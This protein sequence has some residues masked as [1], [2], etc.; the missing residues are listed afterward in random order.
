VDIPSTKDTLAHCPLC[1]TL[2]PR[3]QLREAGWVTPE[4]EARIR[5]I[6]PGWTRPMGACPACVQ[7]ALLFTLL[8]RSEASF[9]SSVQRAWP[10]DAETEYG[11]LPTPLRMRADPR[12]TGRGVTMAMIDSGFYPHV[13]LI[14]PRNRIKAWV[15]AGSRDVSAFYFSAGRTPRWPGWNARAPYQWHG[16]MTTCSAAGNGLLSH[17]FYRGIASEADLVL[18][19][20]RSADGRIDN[21]NITRALYFVLDNHKALGI[22][23]VNLSVAGDPLV[24][25]ERETVDAAVT[26]LVEAGVVVV[27]A[28]GN[29]GERR[30]VQPATAPLALT[31][32]G[33]DDRNT[34]GEADNEVWHSNY[35]ESGSGGGKPELV[36]PSIW[37]VAPILPGTEVAKEA[38]RLFRRRALA[39]V[40]AETRI[41][42][43]KLVTPHYQHVEGTSFA[44]P[45]VS[46]IVASMIEAN[47]RL[48]PGRIRELL[49]DAAYLVPGAPVE[50]Q[51]AGALDAGRAVGLALA[52]YHSGAAEYV[53]S[54]V[55]CNGWV[56]FL[57]HDH[58]ASDV[59]LVG[60]WDE[61]HLPGEAARQI[62]AGLWETR[63]AGLPPG[64]YEY[65]FVVDGWRLIL[66]PANPM[67]RADGLGGMNSVFERV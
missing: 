39:R 44:A 67:R 23:V 52:E 10:I 66:D 65:R 21:A 41:G 36:A 5:Q 60:S 31:I 51:G 59:R 49:Q 15:D 19:Q 28:A 32:G 34:F 43:L 61:W 53:T 11:P 2:T 1:G 64:R 3:S 58:H 45:I 24:P 30:L 47:R 13:E 35:G 22:D 37:V 17:G 62:E 12:F 57:L 50:R 25:G 6:R 48:T 56:R 7:R 14:R 55:Q 16:M 33:L 29:N 8:G 4:T 26:E 42:E 27:A 46:S 54:P 38:R 20:A 40:K 63:I 18:I 9:Q